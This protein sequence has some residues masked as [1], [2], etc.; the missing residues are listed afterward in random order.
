MSVEWHARM[1]AVY[2][3]KFQEMYAGIHIGASVNN[4]LFHVRGK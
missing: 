1:K 4:V 3:F 2:L